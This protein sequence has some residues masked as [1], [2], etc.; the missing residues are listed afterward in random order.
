MHV[1]LQLDADFA[2]LILWLSFRHSARNLHAEAAKAGGLSW[3]PYSDEPDEAV[4]A[5]PF[6]CLGVR[7]SLLSSLGDCFEKNHAAAFRLILT[8]LT[9]DVG[10]PRGGYPS[11]AVNLTTPITCLPLRRRPNVQPAPQSVADLTLPLHLAGIIKLI[12]Y[13]EYCLI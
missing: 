7:A 13:I 3:S 12:V 4:Q 6:P 8:C 1:I 10:S 5:L 9:L 11:S 2:P